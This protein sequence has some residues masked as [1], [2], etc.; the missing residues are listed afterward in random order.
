MV[1]N[2]QKAS[3]VLTFLQFQMSQ[4]TSK[5]HSN[6]DKDCVEPPGE[7]VSKENMYILYIQK[8]VCFN[9]YMGGSVI[10]HSFLY[11]N[12]FPLLLKLNYRYIELPKKGG[13][14][15]QQQF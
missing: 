4:K 5:N 1:L 9:I 12:I 8:T 13:I 10:M 2:L 6:H 14:L 11:H 7:S 3:A 15:R